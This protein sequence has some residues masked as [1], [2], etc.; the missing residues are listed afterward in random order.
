MEYNWEQE[1][2]QILIEAGRPDLADKFE[3][4]KD[5]TDAIVAAIARLVML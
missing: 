4:L 5:E 3:A 2:R 1:V